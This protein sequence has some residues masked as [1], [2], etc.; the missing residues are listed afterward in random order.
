VANSWRKEKVPEKD[1]P[2]HEA[3]GR[4]RLHKPYNWAFRRIPSLNPA[5]ENYKPARLVGWALSENTSIL[6]P[7]PSFTFTANK[8]PEE[9]LF[10]KKTNETVYRRR[11]PQQQPLRRG[12]LPPIEDKRAI[13]APAKSNSEGRKPIASSFQRDFYL[14]LAESIP[15]AVNA[16]GML[17]GGR[18]AAL[19]V[20]GE[21]V[22]APPIPREGFLL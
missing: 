7:G 19:R 8:F 12:R 14:P 22:G 20:V 5:L 1:V 11:I 15:P 6:R 2:T 21:P 9:T 17:G 3:Y 18:A 10:F 4:P 13:P 16:G